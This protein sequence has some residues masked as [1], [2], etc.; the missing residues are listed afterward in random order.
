MKSRVYAGRRSRRR[1]GNVSP[2]K[3]EPV[4]DGFF[5]WYARVMGARYLSADLYLPF[6]LWMQLF[7]EIEFYSLNRRRLRFFY[8]ALQIIP[9]INRHLCFIIFWLGAF[10]VF[11]PGEQEPI[12]VGSKH[13]IW[14]L[15]KYLLINRYQAVATERI[16]ECLWPSLKDP[17][18]TAA[19]RTAISR[20]NSLPNRIALRTARQLISFTGKNSASLTSIEETF[21]V[22]TRMKNGP[23]FPANIT[24]VCLSMRFAR[25]RVGCLNLRNMSKPG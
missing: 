1:H 23:R 22:R 24:G 6:T 4:K 16:I 8:P 15:F 20:L 7:F 14:K 3:K 17:G 18:D 12:G 2:L 13:K 10:R 25:L 21:S 19:L 5:Y 9:E 11:R